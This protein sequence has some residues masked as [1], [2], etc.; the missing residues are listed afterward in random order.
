MS[1]RNHLLGVGANYDDDFWAYRAADFTAEEQGGSV[2]WKGGELDFIPSR[3]H[4]AQAI[5]PLAPALQALLDHV[6]VSA[7]PESAPGPVRLAATRGP[8]QPGAAIQAGV[9]KP[10]PVTKS[11]AFNLQV[12]VAPHLKTGFA[13]DWDLQKVI[14]RV[15]AY[16]FRGD[17]RPPREI[18]KAAGFLPPITRT[19]AKYMENVIYPQFSK[20]LQSKMGTSISFADFQKCVNQ[21]MDPG[22][23]KMFVYYGIWRACIEHES[24]HLGRMLAEEALKGFISTSRATTV[25]KGFAKENGWVYVL[26]VNGGFVVP[27]KGSHAWTAIFGEQEIA[28]PEPVPW[29]AIMGFRQTNAGKKF[30]GPIY[31]RDTFEAS[32]SEAAQKCYDLL[33]GKKQ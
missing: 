4:A 10:T 1:L 14:P 27:K 11:E 5:A 32:E 23:R 18:K 12:G 29:E 13:R 15:Q 8:Q 17:T 30:T 22:L 19:D 7:K 21:S 25:A 31:L 28:M 16:T 9:Y 3:A 24:L 26:F 20:Y 2:E 33:S 6:W